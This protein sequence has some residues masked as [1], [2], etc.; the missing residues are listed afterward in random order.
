MQRIALVL[1]FWLGA[2]EIALFVCNVARNSVDEPAS[3][4]P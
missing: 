3:R 1:C 2:A 4:V